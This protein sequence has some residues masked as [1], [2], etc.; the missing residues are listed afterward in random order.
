[1]EHQRLGKYCDDAA[2][3]VSTKLAQPV[4]GYQ[5]EEQYRPRV[6]TILL[7][8]E[9]ALFGRH[10][11]LDS[12]TLPPTPPCYNRETCG[13]STNILSRKLCS[14]KLPTATIRLWI[15]MG[16][17]RET[18]AA[19]ATRDPQITVVTMTRTALLPLLGAAEAIRQ[20]GRLPTT[21]KRRPRPVLLTIPPRPK[22]TAIKSQGW[23]LR[24][25]QKREEPLMTASGAKC[26]K[27]SKDL[28]RP[29]H[30]RRQ[31]NGRRTKDQKAKRRLLKG[32]RAHGKQSIANEV[33]LDRKDQHLP[34]P[35]RPRS[36]SRRTNLAPSRGNLR[37]LAPPTPPRIRPNH[38]EARTPALPRRKATNALLPG[39]RTNRAGGDPK[40]T[41]EGPRGKR[42]KKVLQCH[43]R[44]PSQASR[45]KQ[46]GKLPLRNTDERC[47]P[48]LR[49]R[50]RDSPL[51]LV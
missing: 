2:Q 51:N 25:T 29:D 34:P 31:R 30:R 7:P 10:Q 11:S 45:R 35:P 24:M 40:R 6:I 39:P 5:F 9:S 20:V 15:R 32:E 36:V 50:R 12:C 14:S 44:I 4:N 46:R 21:R 23:S 22:R 43:L 1:M 48:A 18:G 13:K 49:G 41:T 42:A 17:T 19:I 37:N 8:L 26:Q 38:V 33:R 16:T 27:S 47:L 3:I 28:T